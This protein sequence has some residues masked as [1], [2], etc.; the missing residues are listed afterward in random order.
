MNLSTELFQQ[1]MTSLAAGDATNLPSIT[2]KSDDPGSEQRRGPRF[3]ADGGSRVRLIPL[4]DSFAPGPLDVNVRDISP[5]GVRFEHAGRI[6]LDEQFVLLLPT[7]DDGDLAILC[8]VAYWQP[9]ASDSVAVG[10]KFNRIL[11]QG[12][13]QPAATPARERAKR[14]RRAV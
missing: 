12:S 7:P 1:V 14:M 9:I 11:R 6:H 10:A 5:G 2:L 8:G 13:T 3:A 4:T